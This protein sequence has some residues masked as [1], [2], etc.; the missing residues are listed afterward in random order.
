MC[1]CVR[2]CALTCAT[3]YFYIYGIFRNVFIDVHVQAWENTSGI[4]VWCM[5]VYVYMFI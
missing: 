3:M 2:V 4:C 5:R 1:V